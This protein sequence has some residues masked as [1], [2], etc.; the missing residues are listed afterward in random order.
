MYRSDVDLHKSIQL[1][2]NSAGE[3]AAPVARAHLDDYFASEGA[4]GIKA[5]DA[6]ADYES[7]L[8]AAI[9]EWQKAASGTPD[10]YVALLRLIAK[11]MI[12]LAI[13]EHI[14]GEDATER[15]INNMDQF[16]HLQLKRVK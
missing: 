9:E 15:I 12:L 4:G 14:R 8:C 3:D 7:L 16:G 5:P 2:L 13:D 11:G 6:R 10:E 1:I